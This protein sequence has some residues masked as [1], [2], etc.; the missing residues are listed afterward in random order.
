MTDL[1]S[2]IAPE[3]LRTLG[4]SLLHFVWQGFALAAL[5]SVAFTLFRR[6]SARYIIGVLTLLA[7]VASVAMTFALLLNSQSALQATENAATPVLLFAQKTIFGQAAQPAVAS[8]TDIK[9][10][11]SQALPLLVEFWLV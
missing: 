5:A 2:F 7:M 9:S 4:W 10:L 6:A 1:T 8:A 11:S 3:T